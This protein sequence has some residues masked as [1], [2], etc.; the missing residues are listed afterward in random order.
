[1]LDGD[2]LLADPAPLE[3]EAPP[4]PFVSAGG[5]GS[6]RAVGGCRNEA[7]YPRMYTN[8]TNGVP[9]SILGIR[10]NSCTFVDTPDQL[11]PS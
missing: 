11:A 8:A 6:A 9:V 10:A 5:R 4:E 2:A 3:G 7:S 1:M